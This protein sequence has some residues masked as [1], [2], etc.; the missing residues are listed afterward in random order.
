MARGQ[1]SVVILGLAGLPEQ[2]DWTPIWLKELKVIGSVTYGAEVFKGKRA[3]TFARA[4]ELLAKRRADLTPVK[5]RKYPLEQ[6]REALI[7]ASSK[8]TSGAVKV[9]FAL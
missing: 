3:D 9:S 5:P 7:E 8:R 2:V 1:G 6:Y 4:V